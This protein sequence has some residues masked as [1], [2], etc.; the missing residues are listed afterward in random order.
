MAQ[1]VYDVVVLGGGPGGYTAAIRAAQLGLRTAIIERERLGGVCLN[2]GCVPTKALLRNAEIYHMVKSAGDWG[3][4]AENVHLDFSRVIKRSRGIADRISKGVEFLM[5]KNKIDQISGSGRLLS[6]DTIEV[7]AEGK[8]TTTVKGEH[9]IIATGARPRPIPGVAIDRKRIITST[10]AM[11]LP[12]QPASMVIIGAGAIGIEFASFYNTIGTKV[13]VIEMMPTILPIEDKELTKVLAASLRRQGIQLLTESRVEGVTA[14]PDKVTV[15]VQNATGTQE[16]SA[17]VTLVA[18]GVQGNVETIGLES[19]GVKAERGHIVVDKS[20][21]T[22]VPGVFAVGDVIGPP[23]LAH[24]ASAEAVICVEGIAGRNPEPLDYSTIPGCTYCHPQLAS[25]GF[26][27][28]MAV[29]EGYEVKVGRCPFR[30]LGKSLAIGETEGM[31]KLVFDAKYGELLGAHI[32]GSDATE[33]I[34][35]LVLAKKLEATGP[36]I[37]RTIHAHPTLSEA[38]MEAAA[39]AY[40]EAINI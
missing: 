14:G 24:V 21:G 17:D 16:L 35:E 12:E 28:E 11:A 13:T 18:I 26:T 6:A 31:V 33:M 9:I 3:I 19:L 7:R 8:A 2:W 29:A 1:T 10:E 36:D 40:G 27:E 25:V 37:F 5:K 22:S 30:P 34:A 4:S 23:W 32:L 39:A 38:V 20:Y 15:N